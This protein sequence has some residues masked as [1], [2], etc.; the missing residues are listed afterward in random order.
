MTNYRTEYE[1][2][3]KFPRKNGRFKDGFRDKIYGINTHLHINFIRRKKMAAMD[4]KRSIAGKVSSLK[5]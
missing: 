4:R 1:K 3:P 2:L 5:N